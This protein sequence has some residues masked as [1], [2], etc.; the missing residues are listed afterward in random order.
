MWI[1]T[2]G[3]PKHVCDLTNIFKLIYDW[4]CQT[5]ETIQRLSLTYTLIP[6]ISLPLLNS[7]TFADFP[8]KVVTLP[9][10]Q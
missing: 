7:E 8:G 3:L 2:S 1:W 4:K 9:Q 6:K 10:K 5:K